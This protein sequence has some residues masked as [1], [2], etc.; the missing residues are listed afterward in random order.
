M[1]DFGEQKAI[2]LL[3]KDSKKWGG[4]LGKRIFEGREY[5]D[6]MGDLAQKSIFKQWILKQIVFSYSL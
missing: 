5:D 2:F 1:I 6:E 3:A 4:F